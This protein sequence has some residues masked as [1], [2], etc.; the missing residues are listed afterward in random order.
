MAAK[1]SSKA[2]IVLQYGDRSISYDELIQNMKNKWT[3]DYKKQVSDLKD[4]E[5]YVKPE[6]DRV[7]Y[8]INEGE[9]N[10]SFGL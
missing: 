3:Y 7:Y 6:E 1:K 4:M 2:N 8:V 5:L 9:E 10:G